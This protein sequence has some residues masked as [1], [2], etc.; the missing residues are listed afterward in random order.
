MNGI[1]R[2]FGAGSKIAVR[3]LSANNSTTNEYANF[4]DRRLVSSGRTESCLR[5][6]VSD[7]DTEEVTIS[8]FSLRM[9][10]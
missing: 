5:S 2:L 7:V 6:D 8:I 10:A 9:V 1:S 4:V 3:V